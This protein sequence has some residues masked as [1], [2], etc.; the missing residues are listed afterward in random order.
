MPNVSRSMRTAFHE[1]R[2]THV[3]MHEFH[4]YARQ[5][6]HAVLHTHPESLSWSARIAVMMYF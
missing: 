4:R 6:L 2:H 1:Q 3:H 5:E